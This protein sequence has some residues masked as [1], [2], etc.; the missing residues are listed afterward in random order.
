MESSRRSYS[1]VR[2]GDFMGGL[3][4]G[5]IRGGAGSLSRM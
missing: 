2:M 4:D 1:Y 5:V 3:V